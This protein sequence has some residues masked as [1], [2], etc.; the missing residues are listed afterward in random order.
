M[1]TLGAT[2]CGPPSAAE[3]IEERELVGATAL[4]VVHARMLDV[5]YLKARMSES[6][7]VALRG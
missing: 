6:E 2:G 5:E 3:E 1:L 7:P 4:I